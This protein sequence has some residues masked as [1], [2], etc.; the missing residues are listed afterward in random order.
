MRAHFKLTE[1]GD[2]SYYS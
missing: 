2:V 1:S